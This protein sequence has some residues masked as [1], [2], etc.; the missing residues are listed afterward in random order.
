LT[1]TTTYPIG[2]R[3]LTKSRAAIM[4]LVLDGIACTEFTAVWSIRSCQARESAKRSGETMEMS[5]DLLR[6]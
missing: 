1:R 6:R 2:N 4:H 3:E 5:R